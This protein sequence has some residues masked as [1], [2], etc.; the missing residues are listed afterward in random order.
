MAQKA[1]KMLP[2]NEWLCKCETS[3]KSLNPRN[4]SLSRYSTGKADSDHLCI[5]PYFYCGIYYNKDSWAG[6]CDTAASRHCQFAGISPD[7]F[8]T[9]GRR[10]GNCR[11]VLPF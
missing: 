11:P 5:I 8:F 4:I 2:K 9:A 1:E 7:P 6:L 3:S 10:L